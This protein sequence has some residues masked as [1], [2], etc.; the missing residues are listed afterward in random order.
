[1]GRWEPDARHRMREA[2]LALFS[3]RG[4][5]ETTA[6]VVGITTTTNTK[7]ADGTT[8]RDTTGDTTITES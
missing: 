2:D 7:Y 4:Y 5:A 3:E 6:A 1:M 8:T